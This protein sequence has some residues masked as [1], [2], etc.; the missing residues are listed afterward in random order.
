MKL[1][2]LINVH[3]L[4]KNGLTFKVQALVLLLTELNLH[5]SIL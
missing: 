5:I 4:K 1:S 2:D 3:S